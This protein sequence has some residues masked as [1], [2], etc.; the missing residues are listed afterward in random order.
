MTALGRVQPKDGII[1]VAGPSLSSSVVA[2]LE[3]EEGDPVKTGQVIAVLEQA[4]VMRAAVAELEAAVAAK[5]AAVLGARAERDDVRREESR[6][7]SLSRQGLI[8]IAERERWASR[9]EVAETSLRHAVLEVET[10]RAA[11]KRARL[12]SDRTAVRSPID[13][14]VLK[15]HARAGE[16]VGDDGIA[17]LGRTGEMYVVAEVYDSD[18]P[19]V[20]VG[21]RA[22]IRSP[23]VP[24]PL[25]GV[26]ERIG[27]K[28]GKKDVLG[29]D[30]AARVDVRVV[31]VEIRLDD[32]TPVRALTNLVVDVEI[33]TVPPPAS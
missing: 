21:Q 25:R 8:P 9:L 24:A 16:K 12:D 20:K 11:L 29:T 4:P 22:T 31:E 10:S 1:R 7:D 27:G 13:G 30:P 2:R 18:I 33:A 23:L 17:E 3:V 26:V 32:G 15:L 6:Q 19:A 28:I 5:E 14:R